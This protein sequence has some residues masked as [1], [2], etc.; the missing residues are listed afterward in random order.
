MRNRNDL[1]KRFR[2]SGT[3]AW[4]PC[5]ITSKGSNEPII[6]HALGVIQHSTVTVREGEMSHETV[7]RKNTCNF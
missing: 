6:G 2:N 7:K 4:L 5:R 1:E 3:D